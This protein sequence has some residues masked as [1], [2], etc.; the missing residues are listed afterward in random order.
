VMNGH[1]PPP[2]PPR[3]SS[4][5]R[6]GRRATRTEHG[7]QRRGLRAPHDVR[8]ARPGEP[9]GALSRC[10]EPVGRGLPLAWGTS[11]AYPKGTWAPLRPTSSA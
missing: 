6:A 11:R 2:T 7:E 3:A 1:D 9:A 5:S 4:A 10:P 8:P